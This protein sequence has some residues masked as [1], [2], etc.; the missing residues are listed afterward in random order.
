MRP[1][2]LD[3]LVTFD[4]LAA[5]TT[6]LGE[7]VS[8]DQLASTVRDLGMLALLLGETPRITFHADG[9]TVET[10]TTHTVMVAWLACSLA[11]RINAA[12]PPGD[13]RRLDVGLV[14]IKALVHDAPELYA[15]DTPTLRL[16]SG[17]QAAAKHAAEFASLERI[18]DEVGAV[19]PWLVQMVRGY[20][21]RSSQEDDFVWA[22]DKIS[23]KVTH[24]ANG[25]AT[26]LAQGVGPAELAARYTVQR[27]QI[28]ARAGRW[29][30]IVL[31]YDRLVWEELEVLRHAQ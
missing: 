15:G 29:P 17:E 31:I 3:D 11:E 7:P 24:I 6:F 5:T 13:P 21:A 30:I 27:E 18:D 9:N 23:P 14:A 16:P 1:Q 20:E 8:A 4:P 12:L 2:P 28:V 10:V 22:V 19:L 25:C 26:P